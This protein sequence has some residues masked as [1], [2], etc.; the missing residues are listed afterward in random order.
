MKRQMDPRSPYSDCIPRRAGRL[1]SDGKCQK[2]IAAELGITRRTLLRW[3]HRHAALRI[4][5]SEG[6]AIA[7]DRARG[8]L[9]EAEAVAFLGD[10]AVV[11]P[12]THI[13]PLAPRASAGMTRAT[14]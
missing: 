2:T 6:Q 10:E 3:K 13:V 8:C 9:D 4:A 1:A 5:L 12:L 14:L 11:L 7:Q